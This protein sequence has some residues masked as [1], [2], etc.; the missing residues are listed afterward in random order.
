MSI[1]RFIPTRLIFGLV[2]AAVSLGALPAAAHGFGQRYDLPLPLALYLFGAG[3]AVAVSFLIVGLFVRGAPRGAPHPRLDLTSRRVGRLILHPALGLVLQLATLVAFVVTVAAG[4]IG[5]QDP[6]RNIAPTM[7]WIIFW[8]GLAY[9]SAFAGDIWALVNPLRTIFGAIEHLRRARRV[10]LKYPEALGVWPAFLLLLVFSW[11]ELVYPSPAVP[12]HIAWFATAYA[13]LTWAGMALF[14]SETWI[15]RGEVFTLVFGTFARFA[16]LEVRPRE[17]VCA[18]RPFGAGLL[19]GGPA[20]VSMTAFVLLLLST[21]LYDGLLSTPEWVAA[22]NAAVALL[23]GGEVASIAVRTLGLIGFWFIFLGAFLA[24][25][26][27][28]SRVAGGARS[29]QGMAQDL[30]L[31]LVPIAIGYHL[32][33]YLLLLLVQGQYIVP[34]I[35]DPFGFGWN[36]FGTAGYRVDIAIAGARFAWYVALTAILLGHIAA[37][38]LAHLKAIRIIPDRGAALRAEV[39]LTALMVAYTCLS[40]SILAEPIVE[41]RGAAE[42][43]TAA[44]TVPA[45]ALIPQPGT[46][47]LGAVGPGREARLKLTYRVLGSAFHDGTRMSAAD[48]LYAYMFAW[49]WGASDEGGDRTYDPAIAAATA[50]LRRALVGFRL[51]G[52]DAVSKSFRIGDFKVTR[53]LFIVDVYLDLPPED[54]EQDAALAPPWSTLPWHVVTLMEEA[55]CRGWAAFSEAEAQRRGV[56]WLDLARSPAMNTRLLALVEEFATRGYRP[57]TL[58]TLVTVEE[59]RSRWADLAA[60][61]KERGHFLVTNGPYRLKSWS[62]DGVVLEAFRDLSYPL[63]VG[64]FDAY[65]IPRRGYVTGVAHEEGQLKVNGAIER[66]IKFGRSYRLEVEPIQRIA[67]ELLRRATPECRYVIFDAEGQAVLAG[68]ASPDEKAAF[69]IDIGAKLASGHYTLMAEITV[70]GNASNAEMRRFEFTV[71]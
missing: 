64:S 32:A 8:V 6:Y 29:P 51:A 70:N 66:L 30:A 24:A 63:G 13:L 44:I 2:A 50:P 55:V 10:R 48:L 47:R 59:A 69:A 40:L 5:N 23:G 56:E 61:F 42:A 41:R 7:V 22:E 62:A 60:F 3:F 54:P 71:P 15:T 49:R 37:V 9:V 33:H 17:R 28:M 35:S 67:P 38:T 53:D 57:E 65:A 36:L 52:V 20:S 58:H 16:P 18:L 39:P 19:K 45:D 14:G 34:L 25:A 1:S 43:P 21:V 27:V 46:G 11:T 12:R 68:S 4:F 26:A 31:T